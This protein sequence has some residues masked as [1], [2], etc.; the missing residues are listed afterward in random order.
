MLNKA[1]KLF[2]FLGIAH[3]S[4]AQLNIKSMLRVVLIILVFFIPSVSYAQITDA[5]TIILKSRLK[6]PTCFVDVPATIE[7]GEIQLASPGTNTSA[8]Y[9]NNFN[10]FEIDIYCEEGLRSLSWIQLSSSGNPGEVATG[11][12]AKFVSM[13]SDNA[14]DSDLLIQLGLAYLES[15][16]TKV[17]VYDQNLN[18]WLAVMNAGAASNTNVKYCE[19]YPARTCRFKPVIVVGQKNTRKSKDNVFRATSNVYE[20]SVTFT[21]TYP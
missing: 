9:F 5:K 12:G 11:G 14:T 13:I 1:I 8:E 2:C 16:N 19:G 3:K 20:Q 17:G 21:L 4:L 18:A 15:D 6:K 10:E 7:L